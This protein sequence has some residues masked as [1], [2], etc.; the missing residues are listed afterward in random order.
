[1]CAGS[2]SRRKKSLQIIDLEATF[3]PL[4][5]SDFFLLSL[6]HKSAERSKQPPMCLTIENHKPRKGR[7]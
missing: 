7:G 3:R 4:T 1:M 2:K 5:I 6:T